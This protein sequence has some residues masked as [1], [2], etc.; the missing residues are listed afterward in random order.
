MCRLRSSEEYR[1]SNVYLGNCY[2]LDRYSHIPRAPMF[3]TPLMV[4]NPEMDRLEQRQ[5]LLA[6]DQ[7][8]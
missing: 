6:E 1:R 7:T 4:V 3:E 8:A 5:V 2:R